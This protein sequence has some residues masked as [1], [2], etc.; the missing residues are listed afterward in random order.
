MRRISL[1][2]LI[3]AA[4]LLS[5]GMSPV[6]A[7]E[8]VPTGP[9]V[10]NKVMHP[11]GDH[12]AAAMAVVGAVSAGAVP[13]WNF[14]TTASRDGNSYSG[15]LIG[16]SPFFHGARTTTINTVLIPVKVSITNTSN[17]T[18]VFDPTKPDHTCLGVGGA[19]A[20]SL[21]QASPLLMSANFAVNGVPEGTTQYIDAFQRANFFAE[22]N[23]TGNSYHTLLN[24]TVLPVVSLTINAPS[25][26]L[27]DAPCVGGN[28]TLGVIDVNNF[29]NNLVPTILSSLASQG[30]GPTTFPIL[31]FYNVVMTDGPP[32][33]TEPLSASSCCILGYHNVIGTQ[34]TPQVY[35]VADYD[36]STVLF[37]SES[38]VSIL[39]HEIA[40]SVNDPLTLNLTPWWGPVGQV[41]TGC[42]NNLEVG[43]PLTGTFFPAVTMPNGVSYHL[44]EFAFFSWFFGTP[45]IGAG[46][47]FSDN[48]TF[49]KDAGKVCTE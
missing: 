24:A 49:T 12:A 30:V 27:Q 3:L 5:A 29:D 22:V 2:W 6:S 38:D 33:Q 1:L 48:G 18:I 45:S 26:A 23:P 9:H 10:R 32:P 40:E 31:L 25:G 44:Q 46:G 43:D 36:S 41:I 19:T 7:Q 13:M 4:V 47:V 11:H 16:R 15:T 42:Q 39:S 37:G 20:L 35:A 14:S 34:P 17:S 8:S 21:T 28:T